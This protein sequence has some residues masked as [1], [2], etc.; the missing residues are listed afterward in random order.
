MIMWR[1]LPPEAQEDCFRPPEVPCQVICIHC[2]QQYSSSEIFWAQ[3]DHG[4]FWCC[5][6]PDCG[7]IGFGFDIHP[8][9]SDLFM[10][11]DEEDEQRQRES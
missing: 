5:P 3:T 8:A 9:D 4:G 6:V 10:H 7:G 2:E 1:D 11:D